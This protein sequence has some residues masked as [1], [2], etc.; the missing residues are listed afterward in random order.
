MKNKLL[1]VFAT[2]VLLISTLCCLVSCNDDNENSNMSN[3]SSDTQHESTATPGEA[4]SD[5]L[6]DL[7]PDMNDGEQ[8]GSSADEFTSDEKN[9]KSIVGDFFGNGK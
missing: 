7:L 3:G 2:L 1:T 6:D 4:V 5:I 8:Q 9:N